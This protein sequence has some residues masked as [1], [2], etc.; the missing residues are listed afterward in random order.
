MAPYVFDVNISDDVKS[1]N[2]VHFAG[3]NTSPKLDD[4]TS[5][6]SAL[7]EKGQVTISK[8][9]GTE[10]LFTVVSFW[11]GP[12]EDDIKLKFDVYCEMGASMSSKPAA[13]LGDCSQLTLGS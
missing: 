7:E 12:P 2:P 3:D 8:G 9:G 13:R 1:E 4:T 6:E 5:V 11:V 10:G